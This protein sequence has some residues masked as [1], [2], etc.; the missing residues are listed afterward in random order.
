MNIGIVTVYSV[1]NYGSYLQAVSLILTLQELG[2]NVSLVKILPPHEN[3]GMFFRIRPYNLE[4]VHLPSFFV[5]NYKGMIKYHK[6]MS[7]I[8]RLPQVTKENLKALD[9]VILGSDEIW[10]WSTPIFRDGIYYGECDIASIPYAVSIGNCRMNELSSIPEN[11]L[12]KFDLIGVRDES[13]EKFVNGLGIATQRVVDPTIL[14]RERLHEV[15]GEPP[16][17]IQKYFEKNKCILVYSYGH[18]L[19][20]G[21]IKNLKNYAKNGGFKL[22]SVGFNLDWVDKNFI[23]SPSQFLSVLDLA[24]RVYTT[25]FHGTILSILLRKSFI[26]N[27]YSPKTKDALNWLGLEDR[28]VGANSRRSLDFHFNQQID[29]ER[30]FELIDNSTSL[31]MKYLIDGLNRKE[32]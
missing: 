21:E 14:A 24:D 9:L 6:F 31:S 20:S 23:V 7:D 15:T 2:H 26:S 4:W 22:V 28:I 19:K 12:K 3:R 13:T 27:P 11:W 25:T 8:A 5:K 30:V 10:N 17:R 29:Y 18:E 32:K 16:R 1:P